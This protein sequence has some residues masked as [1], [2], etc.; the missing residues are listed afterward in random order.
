MLIRSASA[1]DGDACTELFLETPGGLLEIVG[2]RTAALRMARAAFLGT[3]TAFSYRQTLVAERDG[4]VFGEVA[5]VPGVAWGRIRIR[6]GL[7]MLRAAGPRFGARLGWRGSV[8]SR[9]TPRVERDSVYVVS[10]AVSPRCRGEGIGAELL[11]TVAQEARSAGAGSVSLDV[12]STN[13]GAI[14]LYRRE[15]FTAVEERHAPA[16]R[17][18]PAMASIRMKRPL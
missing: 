6:T 17:G 13:E 14:R 3:G 10:L 2:D 11:A 8:E 1:A 9:L 7:V 16:A 18:L 12:A 15:G 5:R 4:A